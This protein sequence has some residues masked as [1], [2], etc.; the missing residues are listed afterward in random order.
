MPVRTFPPAKPRSDTERRPEGPIVCFYC[1]QEG[2][3]KPECPHRKPK[4]STHSCIPRPGEG[5]VGFM[6]RL[7]TILVTVNGETVT[8]LL[9]SGSTQTLVQPHLVEKRDILPGKKLK[10]LCVNGD[11]HE[12]LVADVYLQVQGQTYQVTV[13]V[14]ERLS[15][16]VVIGQDIVVLPELLQTVKPVS[17]VVTRAQSRAQAPED[18]EKTPEL[19]DLKELAFADAD[20]TSPAQVKTKKTRRQRRQAKLVGSM[21]K[22]LPVGQSEEDWGEVPDNFGQM[23]REDNSLKG[24]FRQVTEQPS[25]SG[26]HYVVREGLLYHQPAEGRAEQLVVPSQLREKVLKMGHD[27]PWSGHL[28][29]VKTYERI[30]ARFYWPGLYKDVQHFCKTCSKCQL[31]SIRK[32]S[33]YPLQPLPVIE[34][35]FSRIAMDLVGPLERSQTGHRYILVICDYATR[36]P[37]AFPFRKIAARPIAQ[38]LLQLFSRVGIPQE[39]LTDQGTA[40]LSRTM[41][42]VYSLLGIKGIRTTPYHPQ[43][44]GLVE[45]YNQTLKGMLRKFV[46]VNGKDWDRWLPYL[47]FAYQ[48]V[49]QASTGFSPFELLYGRQ[50]RGPLDVL[51]ETWEGPTTPKSRSILAHVIKMRDKMEEMAELVRANMEQAQTQQKA[52]YNKAA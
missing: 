46:A 11:E 34:T 31:T 48:E 50:V 52:W 20:I 33:P 37:E 18:T 3:I 22:D 6:G 8:A 26:E 27:I 43:T 45:R 49:P 19:N 14:V 5:S 7:Q 51:R 28:S 38:A 24:A 12:Y 36:Y 42:Q 13:G 16:P 44:D 10:V 32:T 25:L 47:L 4:Y 15:H 1:K 35:P 2:H 23:Q 21:E 40:F 17:M 41:K 9:D 30:A 29:N 39:V